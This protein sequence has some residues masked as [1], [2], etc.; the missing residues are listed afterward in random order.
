MLTVAELAALRRD[1]VSALPDTCVVSRPSGQPT[2]GGGI[3]DD[4]A[5]AATYPCSVQAFREP[6]ER[7]EVEAGDFLVS[8]SL[9]R[10]YLPFDADIR[11]GD[12]LTA[13][14]RKYHV[15][16]SDGGGTEQIGC[17]AS[18]EYRN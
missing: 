7:A 1:W 3:G 8:A 12:V 14:G 6:R 15:V 17:V 5:V 13:R 10:I 4:F 18:C 2:P 11:P 16:M 9:Y